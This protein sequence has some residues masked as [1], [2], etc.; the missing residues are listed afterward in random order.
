[1]VLSTNTP[2]PEVRRIYVTTRIRYARE[3]L[4]ALRAE[5]EELVAHADQ[6]NSAAARR[7]ARERLAYINQHVPAL[8]EEIARLTSEREELRQAFQ[9]A[10]GSAA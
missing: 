5:R 9:A 2:S 3:E 7:E 1:M 10:E 6:P 4:E 8:R